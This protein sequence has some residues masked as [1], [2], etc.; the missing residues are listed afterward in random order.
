[1]MDDKLRKEWDDFI[2][3][4]LAENSKED[5]REIIVRMILMERARIA[6]KEAFDKIDWELRC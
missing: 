3:R 4:T 1:M 6:A 5:A 2:E